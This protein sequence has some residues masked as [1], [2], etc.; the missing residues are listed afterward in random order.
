MP[1]SPEPHLLARALI[2]RSALD[3]HRR[4]ITK[5]I[6]G[7]IRCLTQACD[8]IATHDLAG[9]TLPLEG[10]DSLSPDLL[11]LIDDPCAGL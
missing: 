4:D 1:K 3:S 2:A 11:R 5:A 8:A 7:R 6:N 9:E 10:V